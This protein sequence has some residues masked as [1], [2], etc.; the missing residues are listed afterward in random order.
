MSGNDD[1]QLDARELTRSI[2]AALLCDRSYM[3]IAVSALLRA[4]RFGFV[5]EVGGRG[6]PGYEEFLHIANK[7]EV[8]VLEHELPMV[9]AEN[10]LNWASDHST[11][12]L[13]AWIPDVE[14]RF[15]DLHVWLPFCFEHHIRRLRERAPDFPMPKVDSLY[16]LLIWTECFEGKPCPISARV[17]Q[18]LLASE[19]FREIS[20][21]RYSGTLKDEARIVNRRASTLNEV[22]QMYLGF[23]RGADGSRKSRK[24]SLE[25]HPFNSETRNMLNAMSPTISGQAA[26]PPWFVRHYQWDADKTAAILKN[27]WM[28]HLGL[29]TVAN[30]PE[31]R[32]IAISCLTFRL[33]GLSEEEIADRLGFAGVSEYEQWLVKH[34]L[35]IHSGRNRCFYDD[36][37]AACT[38]FGLDPNDNL[39]DLLTAGS[40]LAKT[41]DRRNEPSVSA[42][43]TVPSEPA[44]PPEEFKFT[45]DYRT[46]SIRGNQHFLSQQEAAIV[47]VLHEAYENGTPDVGLS[48]LIEV[49]TGEFT[50][51]K[52]LRDVFKTKAARDALIRSGKRRGTYRL[53]LPD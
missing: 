19:P 17:L 11:K 20:A 4:L 52:K 49:A 44:E 18:D 26:A 34:A 31:A 5:L 21:C 15:G 6:N 2:N 41:I 36:W 40:R 45:P 13:R 43:D 25:K 42:V 30:S 28:L 48:H 33:E 12:N 47:R 27:S 38:E 22:A 35:D 3:A 8:K 9:L 16:L 39:V 32:T 24:A 7:L 46:V 51:A 14:H 1:S 10:A 50:S 53:N 23:L 37:I 29:S